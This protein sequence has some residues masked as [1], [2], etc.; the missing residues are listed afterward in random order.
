MKYIVFATLLLASSASFAQVATSATSSPETEIGRTIG[1]NMGTL[2]VIQEACG[3]YSAQDKG[4]LKAGLAKLALQ[5]AANRGPEFGDSYQ[6]GFQEG[7][8][9][10]KNQVAH[11]SADR[12]SSLCKEFNDKYPELAANLKKAELKGTPQ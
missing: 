5:L 11:L 9:L 10:M 8:T 7:E 4:S 3:G 1:R 2:P 6:K 12:L